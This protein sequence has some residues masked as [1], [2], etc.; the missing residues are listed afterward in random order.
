MAFSPADIHGVG[1]ILAPMRATG[2]LPAR[3]RGDQRGCDG[4]QIRRLPRLGARICTAWT[5]QL[6]QRLRGSRQPCGITQD[7]GIGRH[8]SLQAWANRR[9]CNPGRADVDPE[10]RQLRA[11]T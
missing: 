2:L 5:S 11:R 1:E 9:R 10:F 8:F 3:C 4:E 6:L 7:A